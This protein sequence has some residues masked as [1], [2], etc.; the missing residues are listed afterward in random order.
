MLTNKALHSAHACE[1]SHRPRVSNT[2]TSRVKEAP[3]DWATEQEKQRERPCLIP[4]ALCP[5]TCELDSLRCAD[6]L[7]ISFCL[8]LRGEEIP[9]EN[10]RWKRAG[11][12][13]RWDRVEEINKENIRSFEGFKSPLPL[14][15]R[16]LFASSWCTRSSL[17]VLKAAI[18]EER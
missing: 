11:R 5:R 16:Y 9:L 2:N 17:S 18:C 15:V 4:T 3:Q 13:G 8:L 14:C 10:D 1:H 6:A 12:G 7:F